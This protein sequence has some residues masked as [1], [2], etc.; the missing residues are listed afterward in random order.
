MLMQGAISESEMYRLPARRFF[1]Y[2]K[3]A[4]R[5]QGEDY[6]NLLAI[7]TNPHLFD[8]QGKSM[9]QQKLFREYE[10]VAKGTSSVKQAGL[11]AAGLQAF[12]KAKAKKK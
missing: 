9:P 2:L 7:A 10:M 1:V 12:K 6:L 4:C 5:I 11:R 3:H 8:K